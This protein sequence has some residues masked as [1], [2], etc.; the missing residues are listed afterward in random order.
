MIVSLF[1]EAKEPFLSFKNS[2]FCLSKQ[3]KNHTL[4][5]FFLL[6]LSLKHSFEKSCFSDSKIGKQASKPSKRASKQ[7]SKRAS[8]QTIKQASQQRASTQPSKLVLPLLLPCCYAIAVGFYL[9]TQIRHG[10]GI[11]PQATG[12]KGIWEYLKVY[13]G[14]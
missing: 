2:S 13:K 11:L 10:G 12:Y 3:A 5:V 7:A 14:I 6:F 4:L 1:C 9:Q 8:E